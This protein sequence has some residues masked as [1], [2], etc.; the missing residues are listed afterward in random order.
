MHWNTFKQDNYSRD[1]DSRDGEGGYMVSEKRANTT[2]PLPDHKG[3]K[4][5]YLSEIHSSSFLSE[6]SE[7]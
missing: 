5:Q 1:G 7:I 4:L 3:F 6:F 2:S